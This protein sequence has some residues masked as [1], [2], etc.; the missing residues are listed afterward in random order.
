M[1]N[2][3]HI[4][5]LPN[6]TATQ[7]LSSHTV[8]CLGNFDGVHIGHK[9]LLNEAKRQ[10]KRLSAQYP[11]ISCGVVTFSEPTHETLSKTPP[12]RITDL[13]E[14]CQLFRQA[15]MDVLIALDFNSVRDMPPSEFVSDILHKQCNC[16]MTVCG[17]NFR[18]GAGGR[19]DHDTLAELM[20]GCSVTVPP[21]ELNGITVSSTAIRAAVLEGNIE[22][23]NAMLGR[24]FCIEGAVEHGRGVGNKLGFATLNQHFRHG[25]LI[26]AHGVYVSSCEIDGMHFPAVSNVGTH[27]TF[28]EHSEAV[29]ETHI[30]GFCGDLYGKHIKTHLYKFL[31][32]ERKFDSPEQLTAEVMKNIQAAAEYFS[33]NIAPSK[34]KV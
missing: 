6:E 10:K 4:I 22:A 33:N 21:V 20:G 15:D 5:T 30:I 24:P 19:G 32:P 25:Y 27:P 14:K 17:F 8:L 7:P 9:A 12:P 18:F 31:R 1:K 29:C 16:V 2:E 34:K 28:G 3:T 11:N 23:A 26:P 13:N